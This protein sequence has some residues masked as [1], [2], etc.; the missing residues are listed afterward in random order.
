MEKNFLFI[1]GMAA[2]LA[3][4][5]N[6]EIVEQ[7][8]QNVPDSDVAVA[9]TAESNIVIA[10]G[11]AVVDKWSNT[12]IRVWGLNRVS[13]SDW[14]STNSNLFS[15][16]NY[17]DGTVAQNGE[18]Q[19]GRTT[20]TYFYPLSSDVNF[21]FYACS[22]AP[23]SNTLLN[24]RVIAGYQI[25]GNKDILWGEAIAT[26]LE[27]GNESYSGYNARYFRK[28]GTKPTIRFDHMLTQLNFKG[29]KG[30]EGVVD[31]GSVWP[32]RIKNITIRT[33]DRAT[34]DV[35]GGD[36]GTLIAIGGESVDLPVYFGDNT[37]AK[38]GLVTLTAEGA[39]AGT[40]MVLPS[41][42]GSYETSITLSAVVNGVEKSVTS[43][44]SIIYK[45]EKG[46]VASFEAGK[47]YTVRLMIYGLRVVE[48]VATLTPWDADTEI[49]DQE[50]N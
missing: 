49:I 30:D 25:T 16:T 11:R 12:P 1:L 2:V 20:D 27:N 46:E 22:P 44:V 21:S 7:Q 41:A 13:G 35:A 36:K 10:Q 29:V 24:D 43:Q 18:V 31:A 40:A 4:C 26:D 50:V 17:A 3:S 19:L 23:D 9:L 37:Y 5:S 8:D 48:L 33:S 14:T 34:L 47:A 28:G 15:A 39:T 38:N 32:V 42:A 45:N 6:D